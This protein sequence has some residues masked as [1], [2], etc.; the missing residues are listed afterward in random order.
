MTVYMLTFIVALLGWAPLAFIFT[1][2]ITRMNKR[3]DQIDQTLKMIMRETV[4]AEEA[5]RAA[6][7]LIASDV[8]FINA[9]VT[10]HARALDAHD[11]RLSALEGEQ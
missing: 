8:Q 1:A 4:S 9:E 2:H 10:A 6:D 5:L 7:R 11:D 3:L